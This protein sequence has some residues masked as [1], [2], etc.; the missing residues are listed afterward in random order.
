MPLHP[1]RDPVAGRERLR[2]E[3]G[4]AAIL[5]DDGQARGRQGGRDAGK[6]VHQLRDVTALDTGCVWGGS[7]TAVRLDREA[8]PVR[9]PCRGSRRPGD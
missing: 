8:K 7:L 2:V 1:R 9:L 6:R 4:P 3:P 5:A